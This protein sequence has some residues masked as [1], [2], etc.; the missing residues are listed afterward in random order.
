MCC[1]FVCIF[2]SAI[3]LYQIHMARIGDR[4]IVSI[5]ASLMCVLHLTLLDIVISV[6][7]KGVFKVK[8]CYMFKSVTK[9]QSIQNH[10]NRSNKAPPCITTVEE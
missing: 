6:T 1:V 7:E 3:G 10:Q 8:G 2:F 5:H 9:N 4:G